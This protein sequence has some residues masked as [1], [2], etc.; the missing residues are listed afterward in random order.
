VHSSTNTSVF[1]D[2]FIYCLT[3]FGF[4]EVVHKGVIP[5]YSSITKLSTSSLAKGEKNR[6]L[7]LFSYTVWFFCLHKSALVNRGKSILKVQAREYCHFSNS[8][9]TLKVPEEFHKEYTLCNGFHKAALHSH[10]SE[11]N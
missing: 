3:A 10:P 9:K 6:C 2:N 8:I 5:Q 4:I 1:H 11:L 7:R